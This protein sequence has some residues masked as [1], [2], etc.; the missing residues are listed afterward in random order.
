M[1]T[2]LTRDLENCERRSQEM[3]HN[4]SKQLGD[5]QAE[6]QQTIQNLKKG[7]ENNCKKLKEEKAKTDFLITIVYTKAWV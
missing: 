2:R 1:V 4:L 6:Y 5:Q 7:N 3:K